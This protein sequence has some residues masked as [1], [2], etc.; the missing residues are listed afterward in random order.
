[1]ESRSSI[2]QKWCPICRS[3]NPCSECRLWTPPP[4]GQELIPSGEA[5][6]CPVWANVNVLNKTFDAIQHLLEE[7]AG[8]AVSHITEYPAPKDWPDDDIELL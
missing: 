6:G 4:Q 2:S 1:M 3:W 8:S 5:A 7:L